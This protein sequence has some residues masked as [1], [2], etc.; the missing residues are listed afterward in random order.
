[1]HNLFTEE[2][3]SK[4]YRS[5]SDLLRRE[6]F[7]TLKRAIDVYTTKDDSTI[8]FKQFCFFC[9]FGSFHFLINTLDNKAKKVADFFV[10]LIA[11]DINLFPFQ[12]LCFQILS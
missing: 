10:H 12:Y 4:F 9:N 3:H 6:N 5:S 2:E 8:S 1:M 11:P 7:K